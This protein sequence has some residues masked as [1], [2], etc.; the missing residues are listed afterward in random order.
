M[1]ASLVMAISIGLPYVLW[2]RNQ[3]QAAQLKTA[4]DSRRIEQSEAA[5]ELEQ[6]SRVQ[7]EQL[8]AAN[9]ARAATQEY[10]V[11]IMKVRELRM[12]PEPKAGWT[13]E[14]LDLLQKAATSNADGKDPVVLRSL[15]ADT[16]MTPDMRE[17]GRIEGGPDTKALA[18]SP[19]GTLLAAGDQTGNPSQVRIYR[20]HTRSSEDNRQSVEF[21]LI[22]VCS[23][24]TVADYMESEL[25]EKGLKSGTTKREGMRSLDFSPDGTKIAVGTRNGNI[26][27]WKIDCEP[28]QIL[29]DKRYPEG[30]IDRL[31]F[32]AD[33]RQIIAKCPDP[34]TLRVFD[35]DSQSDRVATFGEA[36]DFALMPDGRILA[37]QK[38]LISR[39]SAASFAES[40]EFTNEAWFA[41]LGTDSTQ[42]LAIVGTVPAAIWDPIT[43]E[44]SL[45]LAQSPSDPDRPVGPTFAADTTIVLATAEPQN[46]RMWDA[47]SGKQAIDISYSG[48]ELPLLCP[49]R[50]R[51][52]V[53]VNS[54][55]HTFAYQLRCCQ[56]LREPSTGPLK[57]VSG[58][59]EAAERAVEGGFRYDIVRKRPPYP[60]PLPQI[61]A[62]TLS[63][64][65][66][67]HPQKIGGEG[68]IVR[69]APATA[70][71]AIEVQ[72]DADLR[73][74]GLQEVQTRTE[75]R[76]S[77]ANAVSPVAAFAPG[78][79]V[80]CD[81]A[82]SDDQQQM[83]VVEAP[84][85]HGLQTIPDGYRARLRMLNAIDGKETARW[86]CLLLSSGE[87]RN[88][89]TEGD[90]VTFP[91]D[92]KIA[93]TTPAVGNIAV[94]SESGFQFPTGAGVDVQ[95]CDAVLI[96]ADAATWTGGE[97]P[98]VSETNGFRPAIELKLPRALTQ[99]KERLLIRQIVGE[100]V[101][102]Y[103]VSD[104]HLDSAG[105]HLL[106][107]DQFTEACER[108]TWRIQVTLVESNLHFESSSGE[109]VAEKSSSIQVGHLF[110]MPWKRLTRGQTSPVY[111]LRLGPLARRWDNGLAAVVESWTLY[112][113]NSDLSGVASAPWQDIA[114]S[115]EDI[116][117]V[118]ASRQGCF[119][120][121][122]SGLVAVV[123]PDGS[124][125]LI[126][127]AHTENGPYDS[128]DGVLTSAV[129]NEVDLAV[130]GTLR[131]QIK[132]YDLD[133]KRGAPVSITD[134]HDREIVALAITPNGQNLASAAADGVLRHWRR[135]DERLEL[136]Y[137][138]TSERTPI[139]KMSLSQ[140]GRFL[141][142]LRKGERGIRRIDLA[143]LGRHFSRLGIGW[144]E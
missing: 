1:F 88:T 29:F 73:Q 117:G 56:P 26:K 24:S 4:N 82:L 106:Y 96:A 110:L 41:R 121:T 87:N 101:R 105:W 99:S 141:Y 22:R 130:V 65:T 13:W 93:F 67:Q 36:L 40:V 103:E 107:L 57:K 8:A 25:I 108:G 28:P 27:I 139:V 45:F 115:T 125:E 135:H 6:A 17:I 128:R 120:G 59:L 7:A 76:S 140:D 47:V 63:L 113:W 20:I 124:Q 129:A 137:E 44:R 91:D 98:S 118:S 102:E 51:D 111:P 142:V 70:S 94:A 19:D 39:I 10:F 131:G 114:N 5:R 144:D 54:T 16:V 69:R 11:S 43:G 37:S 66:T 23:V 119:V 123:K 46:V 81:F 31:Q 89:L 61:F 74:I 53:Y 58:T 80:L 78:A 84:S 52:R 90:G 55:V 21:E 34:A 85:V 9:A 3:L 133:G 86:T 143:Q 138:L 38:G 71:A 83:A 92:G 77:L 72:A 33:G 2:H 126:E 75:A 100:S 30:E 42:C 15:I 134:A 64:I 109:T 97:V 68:A 116:L 127:G 14:A 136:L 95:E 12:Q 112:Q 104:R 32:S 49:A 79:Q 35:V 18:V 122:D 132:V 50:E 48:D 62:S 60:S